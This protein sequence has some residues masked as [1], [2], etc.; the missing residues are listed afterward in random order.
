MILWTIQ[1]ILISTLLICLIHY[2]YSFFEN[3]LT[4]PKSNNL[5]HKSNLRYN[6]DDIVEDGCKN[7][8]YYSND[9]SAMKTDSN[10]MKTDNSA[11]KT[12][13]ST[14]KTDN[15]TMQNFIKTI[16]NDNKTMEL[17]LEQYLKTIKSTQSI[18]TQPI[19]Y[20][21]ENYTII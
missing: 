1:W 6:D 15:S 11:M 12:D 9:N 4:I 10:T 17:E 7:D 20:P 3:I 14:M 21:Q 2:L 16:P 18:Q 5:I 13:N 8:I 19:S